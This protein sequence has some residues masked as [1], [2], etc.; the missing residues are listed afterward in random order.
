MRGHQSGSVRLLGA[1]DRAKDTS[2]VGV[3]AR[4]PSLWEGLRRLHLCP[5]SPDRV[6]CAPN[7]L[8]DLA[9][10]TDLLMADRRQLDDEAYAVVIPQV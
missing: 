8:P 9:N 10:D 5:R 1:A 4:T 7:V 3:T 6:E 2:A